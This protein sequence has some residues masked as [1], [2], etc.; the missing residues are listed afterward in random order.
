M[1]HLFGMH[2]CIEYCPGHVFSSFRFSVEQLIFIF[3]STGTKYVCLI[4]LC[5]HNLHTVYTYR[6]RRWCRRDIGDGLI[7]QLWRTFRS[8]SPHFISLGFSSF[9]RPFTGLRS[10]FLTPTL[11]QVQR[12]VINMILDRWSWRLWLGWSTHMRTDSS[13]SI[14]LIAWEIADWRRRL[15]S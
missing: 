13:L 7:K 10:C 15:E 5:F 3:V 6:N 14:L 11:A 12:N 8:W 2:A 9:V 4:C 1:D